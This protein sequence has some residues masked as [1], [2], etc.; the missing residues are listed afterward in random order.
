MRP[1]LHLSCLAMLLA[2]GVALGAEIKVDSV[3]VKLI[4]QREKPTMPPAK[5]GPPLSADEIKLI[6]DWIDAGAPAGAVG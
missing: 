3:L 4:E 1:A 5:A 6:R 2:P